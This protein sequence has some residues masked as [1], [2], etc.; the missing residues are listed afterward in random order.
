MKS[1][2]R[3]AAVGGLLAATVVGM[4]TPAP[5]DS[6]VTTFLEGQLENP[7][8]LAFDDADD[9]YIA[10]SGSG[11]AGPCME[12]PQGYVC[13]GTSGEITAVTDLTDIDGSA[14]VVVD[15]LPSMASADDPSTVDEVEPSGFAAAG[16]A[17]V[18]AFGGV[19]FFSIGLGGDPAV[20][21]DLVDDGATRADEFGTIRS[22]VA[23]DGSMETEVA[24]VA[25]HEADENPDDGAGAEEGHE[26]D[27]NPFGIV[28]SADTIEVVDSGGNFQAT[29]TIGDGSVETSA[30]FSPVMTPLPAFTGAPVG[31]RAPAQAVPTQ[32]VANADGGFDVG[33]LTGFPFHPGSSDIMHTNS[34]LSTLLEGFTNV[35]D[36]AWG[37]GG[38]L[39]VLEFS[40]GGLL[41]GTPGALTRVS[42][43]EEGVATRELLADDL[44]SP[45]GIAF[46][47]DGMAYITVGSDTPE[48]SLLQFDVENAPVLMSVTDD[49]AETIEDQPVETDAVANDAE[50]AVLRS[51]PDNTDGAI[52]EGSVMYQPAAHFSGDDS[53][54]YEACSSDAEDAN[55]LLGVIDVT[56]EAQFVDRISGD[57]RIDTAIEASRAVFPDGAPTVVIST[58]GKYPD[59]LAGSVLSKLV[60]GPILLN[61]SNELRQSVID[62]INRLGATT[63]YILGGEISVQPLVE[64]ALVAETTVETVDR[65]GGQERFE[66][67]KLIKEKIEEITG[68][69]ATEVYVTE[70]IHDD[71]ARGW[72]DAMSASSLAAHEGKPILLVRT[73][74]LPDKT[75]E[76]LTGVDK[77]TIVGGPVAVSEAVADDIDDIVGDVGRLNGQTRYGTSLAVAD[78]AKTA[79]LDPSHFWLASGGNWP[80]ALVLGPLV[81]FDGGVMML[82]HP[83]DINDG[84]ET[85]AFIESNNPFLDIDL[86]GGPR[87]ISE[88]V[89]QQIDQL[90]EQA[91]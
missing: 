55:C 20:R 36:L 64:T 67:A 70:G 56:V 72:P 87:W 14:T 60:G 90:A 78:A 38:M 11:G 30:V 54:T 83:E 22:V 40:H 19:L 50:G 39:Y 61:P 80:D 5:A 28:A 6:H 18:S 68:E 79:G 52:W 10:E 34:D 74:E 8:G 13:Y 57:G 86:V 81:A 85:A 26:I 15:D 29:V 41:S 49:T 88:F 66:T 7:R 69:D 16:P 35:M 84:S 63:A 91:S 76:A 23:A 4:G 33:L 53:I 27:S 45:G 21:Q 24:D 37:P 82:V 62:E 2:L 89:R 1:A 77:A 12:G 25:Q 43:D 32:L 44:E 51:I 59:A 65:V 71:P 73:D 17:D 9:L 31:T 47:P 75:A 48:G 3:I 58:E 46:G 42:W